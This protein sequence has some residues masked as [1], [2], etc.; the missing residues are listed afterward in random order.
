[1]KEMLCK[2]SKKVKLINSVSPLVKLNYSLKG[3]SFFMKRDDLLDFYFGGNKVRLYEY[4]MY[5]VFHQKADKLITFGS[6][7]SNHIRVTAAVAAYFNLACDIIVLLERDCELAET[8][9][10]GTL[11]NFFHVNRYYCYVD[12][13]REFINNYIDKQKQQNINCFF[14]PGGGHLPIAALGYV[15]AL[16]EIL[17]QCSAN[18]I[19]IDAVF[20]PTGTGTTQAGLIY[21][22]KIFGFQGDIVGITVSRSVERCKEEILST[23]NGLNL[24]EGE[25]V[26]FSPSDIKVLDNRGKGY[27][28]IDDDIVHVMKRLSTSDGILLDPIYNG[29]SFWV[30]QQVLSNKEFC[31]YRNVLYLNTGGTPNIFTEEVRR[32]VHEK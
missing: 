13:A 4:I 2:I 19:T 32:K 28:L 20:T 1:M 5:E 9:G 23:L 18:N 26:S 24:L 31:E 25:N 27:G 30:M 16:E 12:E 3:I 17:K 11:L 6:V 10:N 21:G 14:V 7:H 15:D 29:K 22:K 8:E